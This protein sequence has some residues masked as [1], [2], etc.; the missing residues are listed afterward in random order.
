MSVHQKARAAVV[1]ILIEDCKIN[2]S[3][4]ADDAHLQDDLGWTA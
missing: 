3:V 4:I 2:E 1:S